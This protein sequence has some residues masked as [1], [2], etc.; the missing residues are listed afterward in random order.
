M[1][2]N[3]VF[4][5]M[6]TEEQIELLMKAIDRDGNGEISYNE[7]LKAFKIV[8]TKKDASSRSSSPSSEISSSTSSVAPQALEKSE[9]GK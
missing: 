5:M 6:L 2:L 3:R 7:F 8:D 4:N 1:K 9:T